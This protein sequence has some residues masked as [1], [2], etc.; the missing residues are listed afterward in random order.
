M[1]QDSYGKENVSKNV[2]IDITETQIQENVMN[3]TQPIVNNVPDQLKMIV[4]NVNHH[5]SSI[6]KTTIV[7]SH[8]QLVT[9]EILKQELV[10]YAQM[11]TVKLVTT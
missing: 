4:P 7:I 1:H 10:T 9:T 8:A 6:Q 2:P 11:L 3:V 5:T